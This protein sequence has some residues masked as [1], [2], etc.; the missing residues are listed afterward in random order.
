ML[1][2]HYV[3]QTDLGLLQEDL[4]R[5]R[6]VSRQTINT[7][8]NNKYDLSLKLAFR[9]SKVLNVTVDELFNYK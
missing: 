9:L 5:K 3:K 4:A 1:H 7:I 8:E 2:L 6:G